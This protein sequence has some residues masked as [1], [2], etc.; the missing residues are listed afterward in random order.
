M[1]V[2]DSGELQSASHVVN[3]SSARSKAISISEYLHN[4]RIVLICVFLSFGSF[5]GSF[6]TAYLQTACP[7]QSRAEVLL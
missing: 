2:A 1:L 4:P 3:L 5:F 6:G 7:I